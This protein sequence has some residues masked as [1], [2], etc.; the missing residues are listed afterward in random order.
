[1][2]ILAECHCLKSTQYRYLGFD[3]VMTISS[4]TNNLICT[5]L[6]FC[7]QIIRNSPD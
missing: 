6:T 3:G 1:M 5:L 7:L 2:Q 4:N